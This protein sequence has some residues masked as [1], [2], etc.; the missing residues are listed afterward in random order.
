MCLLYTR[1]LASNIP[2]IVDVVEEFDELVITQ[3]NR[4]HTNT[5]ESLFHY[6][7]TL[8]ELESLLFEVITTAHATP[9]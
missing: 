8:F 7:L 9:C 1:C 5:T 6:R 4:T 3:S 2:R